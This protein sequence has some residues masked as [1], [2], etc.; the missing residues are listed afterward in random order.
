MAIASS[1]GPIADRT[2]RFGF[3]LAVGAGL[4]AVGLLFGLGYLSLSDTIIVLLLIFPVYLIFTATAL[5]VW[6]GYDTD[7]TDLTRVTE[8]VETEE[9]DSWEN[10]PW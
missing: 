1:P 3:R 7:Q 6:L 8:E 9:N 5:S 2:Y 4:A 10:W